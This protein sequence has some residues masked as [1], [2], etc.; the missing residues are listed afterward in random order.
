VPYTKDVFLSD[1]GVYDNL[2]LETA[3]KRYRTI[4]VSD[5]GLAMGAD[6]APGTDWVTHAKRVLD[7]IDSQV[8]S[9]RKRQL[10]SS[11]TNGMRNGAYWSIR[12]DIADYDTPGSLPCPPASVAELS[13]VPT[14]LAKMPDETQERLIN[15]GYAICDA[16]MRRWVD[17]ALPAPNGF[18]YPRGI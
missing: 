18:P 12:S 3:W 9:L 17:P 11:F 13:R 6:P 2:G 5:A 4:L 7:M 10:L 15:W 8:R 14:R 16:A 1:G